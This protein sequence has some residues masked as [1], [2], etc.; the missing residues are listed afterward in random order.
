MPY[1]TEISVSTL[2]QIMAQTMFDCDEFQSALALYK[3]ASDKKIVD[4]RERIAECL[5]CLGKYE[6]AVVTVHQI[7]ELS[8]FHSIL[9][10]IYLQLGD[11]DKA[12]YNLTYAQRFE[13]AKSFSLS[14]DDCTI[15]R[16]P[17][18]PSNQYLGYPG[19]SSEAWMKEMT[20]NPTPLSIA[21]TLK[22][23]MVYMEQKKYELAT[24]QI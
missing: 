12:E 7:A 20:N 9:G 14:I 23:G 10:E 3:Y 5:F 21:L 4:R 22:L 13:Y 16:L 1:L 11:H 19:N 2:V 15:D 24:K 18:A 6:Q 17:P 8:P